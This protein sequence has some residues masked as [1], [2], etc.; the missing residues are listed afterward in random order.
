MKL[1]INFCLLIFCSWVSYSQKYDVKAIAEI[2]L[3]HSLGQLRAVPVSLGSNRPKSVAA[4]YSEDAEIDPYI[5][6]F[7]FPRHTLKL[8]VFD[9]HGKILCKRDLG[10]GMV[11][12]VWFSPL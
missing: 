9:E 6:M 3:G 11:P 1:L 4:M 10:E 12:G 7:F 8:M 2:D 5:G